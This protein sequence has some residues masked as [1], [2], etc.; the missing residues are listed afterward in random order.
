[1][2]QLWLEPCLSV[3]AGGERVGSSCRELSWTLPLG[4]VP[5]EADQTG[6]RQG[7]GCYRT[8]RSWWVG[9]WD[10]RIGKRIWDPRVWVWLFV[11]CSEIFTFSRRGRQMKPP[12]SRHQR[13]SSLVTLKIKTLWYNKVVL[14]SSLYTVTLT[15]VNARWLCFFY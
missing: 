6:D 7:S 13:I 10:P 11:L 14:H 15:Q 12:F 3:V 1:M 2:E 9:G 4:H 5:A 8:T